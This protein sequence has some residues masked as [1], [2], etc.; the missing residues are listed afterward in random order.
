M[1]VVISSGH[2]FKVR[3]A[4]GILDEVNEARRV[5]ERVAEELSQHGVDVTTFHDDVSTTQ[6][7]NLNRIVDFHNDQGA[8]D[9]DVSV[10]FNAYTETESPMGTECLYVTQAGLADLVA[11]NIAN[12]SGLLDRGPKKR[13]DLFFLNQTNE[14]SILIEV[15]F[16][17]SEAD[18]A[19]YNATFG[20][21][22]GAIAESISGETTDENHVAVRPAPKALLKVK[23]KVSYFGG[24]DDMGVDSDE[25]LAFFYDYDDAPYLF[26]EQQ[27]SGTTGLA[28][29]LN[30]DRP[31]V[32]CRWD[33]DVTPKDMLRQPYPALVRAPSTGKQF[34]AWPADWG[35]HQDTGRV[36][37]ISPS[38]MDR[39][40]ITTD[41]EVE[42]TYPAPIKKFFA[43]KKIADRGESMA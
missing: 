9:L 43:N 30:V 42:V 36:A 14:P 16:V 4:S 5:V 7:E 22:C 18:A 2:G 40:G 20:E 37:D 25:G 33:Y 8:H 1:K 11:E 17:D 6:N 10:H 31:Y 32:A 35:P 28:R 13:T 27:P 41:G 29:R 23:G 38:L 3:G 34:L 26:L 21:I 15:C 19:I 12:V 24:P 39:L